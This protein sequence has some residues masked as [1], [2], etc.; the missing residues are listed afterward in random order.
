MLIL[1]LSGASVIFFY[2]MKSP[3]F[4]IENPVLRSD[5]D[6]IIKAQN[7]AANRKEPLNVKFDAVLFPDKGIPIR[8]EG[9]WQK[10]R[11]AIR[12]QG[13]DDMLKEGYHSVHVGFPGKDL[14]EPYTVVFKN[15]PPV[16]RVESLPSDTDPA[17]RIIRG[18]AASELQIPGEKISVDLM[19]F[20]EGAPQKIDVPVKQKKDEKTG[21]I[22]FEFETTVQGLPILKLG[23]KGY[24]EPF[25]GF[26]VTD[27]AENT[28]YQKFS[29]AQYMA[30]GSAEFGFNRLAM[31]KVDKLVEKN[32]FR[33][34]IR[35]TPTEMS[36]Q[37][38]LANGEQAIILKVTGSAKTAR[39]LKIQS[40]VRDSLPITIVLRDEKQIGVTRIDEYIDSEKLD[41]KKLEYRVEQEGAGG[42]RYTSKTVSV[43]DSEKNMLQIETEP[44]GAT[45][46]ADNKKKG[47]SPL[48]LSVTEK[49]NLRAELSGYKAE[50]RV[51]EFPLEN[52]KLRLKLEPKSTGIYLRQSC[53][54][55]DFPVDKSGEIDWISPVTVIIH[56]T[57]VYDNAVS[58]S[59]TG[60]LLDF[61]TKLKVRK[62]K[63]YRVQVSRIASEKAIGWVNRSALFCGVRPMR[64][65]NGLEQKLY[66]RTTITRKDQPSTVIRAYPSPDLKNCADKC[67]ELSNFTG[68]FVFDYDKQNE[69]YLL[70]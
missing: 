42:T 20:H 64:N 36:L 65:D 11:F 13:V 22:Y 59:K 52:P 23:D 69:S 35:F 30:P 48:E 43:M 33:N 29:Y 10:W 14:S 60:K 12:E 56:N 6:M 34:I 50:S 54:N 1:I 38:Q 7:R 55:I 61:N 58:L 18:K 9:V 49:I 66:T 21:I 62:A 25:F 51:I 41:M 37:Q 19:Y 5:A 45:V 40:N 4:A 17:E 16:L 26:R 32:D 31:I 70:G 44:P 63:R 15:R 57:P 3:S 67:T 27:Q 46:Y 53:W 24:A 68:Y 39:Y 2:N 28:Y 47:I 8:K